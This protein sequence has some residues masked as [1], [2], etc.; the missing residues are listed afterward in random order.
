MAGHM[1]DMAI[2]RIGSKKDTPSQFALLPAPRYPSMPHYPPSDTANAE[3]VEE[4]HIQILGMQCTAC[5]GSIEK[6]VKRLP[7]IE[8]ATV[9][10]IQ[11]RAQ[12]IYHPAFI[13]ASKICEAIEDAGF[14][15]QILE[16]FLEQETKT[17]CRIRIKGMTCTSCS[18]SI[19]TSMM[20]VSGVK[21]AD[22]SLATE[23][24]VIQYNPKLI[25]YKQIMQIIDDMGYMTDLISAG[26]DR[27]KVVLKIDGV[28][29]M[30]AMQLIKISLDALP[31][32][33]SVEIDTQGEKAIIAYDPEVT[34]PRAFIEVIESTGSFPHQY[35]ASLYTHPGQGGPDRRAEIKRYKNSFLWS[36]L[37]TVPVFLLSMV[38]MY[39]PVIKESLDMKVVNML[40]V[41]EVLRWI[42]AT[43]VQ[44]VFGRRFYVGAFRSLRRGSANMDV[45]V[46]LGT[47]AAYFYSVYTVL[48]AATSANFKGVD[49]FETSALLISFI[50][51]GKYLEILARGKTSEA[52]AKLMDLAPP[53]AILLCL[54]GNGNVISE[55]EISTKLIQRNDIIKVLPGS[56][57]PTDGV[58]T[59]G[60][61]HVNESMITGEAAPVPKTQGDKVIGGT[62]NQGGILYVKATHVGSETALSQIVQ[63]VEA[64]QMAKAPVQK[65]ADGISGYFVPFVVAFAAATWVG[66][67]TAGKTNS[68]PKSWIP[69]SMD[70]FE[71]ALQFGVSVL[72]I[73][74]P[75]ALGLATP[76]A[77]MVAT[78][79]GAMQGVL[80]KG[81]HALEGAHKIHQMIF[82]K[83]GTLTMGKPVVVNTK[84]FKHMV[85]QN[86]C[87]IVA[88]AEASSEHP[89]ARAIVDNVKSIRGDSSDLSWLPEVKNFKSLVGQGVY[90]EVQGREVLVGNV[91]LM[92]ASNISL[93]GEAIEFVQDMEKQACT[94]ILVA[95]DKEIYGALAISDP[96][97]PEAK[98]VVEIL[99]SMGVQ[100]LMVTGDNW[101]TANAIAREVGIEKVYAE[102]RPQGKAEIVKDL[103]STGMAVAMVGDGINDS[104]ALVAAD[105]GMAIGAGT[106][107]AIEAADIVL[108]KNNLEDVVTAIHLSRKT[109]RRIRLNYI[110][111]FGYNILGIPIAAGVLFPFTGF[112]LPPW[113]AGAAMAAS[114]VSVV[115]SS[116][117]LKNYKKPSKYVVSNFQREN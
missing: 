5:A 42:L 4:I 92:I 97:K 16:G 24:A 110:W 90:A 41:G 60:Q 23:E 114:S 37:F 7:G 45:L 108:M 85:L 88:A 84:L 57:V 59:W 91:Q 25:S 116:L 52:I 68:Y 115:L 27:D 70:A 100:I 11:N 113:V 14:E 2:Q 83:T 40:T 9:S 79:E 67:F 34:G 29:S 72:V 76:T 20:K 117:L 12:V 44:F 64:A 1:V 62:M 13:D 51:L 101:G 94:A 77:V 104:P 86:F 19:E 58:V 89:L 93:P 31:G 30:D 102:I 103:Q 107:I 98:P 54:D 36:C 39:T 10:V 3:Q 48:R 32:V 49:F 17:V 50:L 18:T 8:D 95:I 106:D 43:P 80:I 73:A 21:K 87:E 28:H 109:F 69:S 38:F 35:K 15:A 53:T 71:L 47:N 112:R 82:D 26:E 78:G 81:G 96:V 61:S 74:C 99:K 33:K 105:V 111:A 66:W 56:K 65:L 6:A 46:A 22:I 63:L 55:S 75:C